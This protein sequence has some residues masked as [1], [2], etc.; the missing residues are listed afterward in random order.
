M[1]VDENA[2]KKICEFIDEYYPD[3]D[4]EEG[5]R[6]LLADGFE[7]AFLGV[8]AAFYNPPCAIYDYEKCIDL[9][10][11]DGCDYEEAIEYFEFNVSGAYVGPQTPLFIRVFKK[12][13]Q[14]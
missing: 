12:E 7:T 8:G 14:E 5:N 3:D 10:I 2:R 4:I 1:T 6:I 13:A 9:L 11:R